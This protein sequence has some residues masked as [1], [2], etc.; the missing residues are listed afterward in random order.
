[1]SIENGVSNVLHSSGVLWAQIGGNLGQLKK[2]PIAL[3]PL[4]TEG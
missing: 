4:V 3:T 2:Y 1:M